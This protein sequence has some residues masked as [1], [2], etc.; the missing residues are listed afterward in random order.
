[1][2]SLPM[3]RVDVMSVAVPSDS[4]AVPRRVEP[5]LKLTVPVGAVVPDAGR[6]VAVSVTASPCVAC[7]G[8]AARV[9]VVANGAVGVTVTI[10][11]AE[12]DAS[13]L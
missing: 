3:G 7:V 2:E 6:T 8:D 12:V 10:T 9:V 5:L 11:G 4:E 1:M 13:K